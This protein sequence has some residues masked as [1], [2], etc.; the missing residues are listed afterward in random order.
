MTGDFLKDQLPL[1]CP[2]EPCLKT[3]IHSQPDDVVFHFRYQIFAKK[4]FYLKP[5][6]F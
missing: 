2:V 5:M 3:I 4:A 1:L 6:N